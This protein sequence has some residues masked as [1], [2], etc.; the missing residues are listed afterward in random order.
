MKKQLLLGAFILGSIFATKAQTGASCA[1]AIPITT[2]GTKTAS[3]I[4][5]TFGAYCLDSRTNIKAIWY[6]YTATTNGEVTIS[7]DL[8]VNNGTLYTN[9][10]RVSVL[11]GAT[12]STLEA[13]IGTNDDV[14]ATNYLSTLT[15]PV[16]AGQ[17][18]WIQ[19][20]NYWKIPSTMGFQFTF[21]FNAV[22]CVRPGNFDFYLPDSYSTTGASLY[23]DQSI[24]SPANY[25]VDWSTDLA[26]AP[27]T[28]TIVS[29]PAGNLDYAVAPLSGLPAS[30]NFRYYVR[31]TCSAM[32]SSG[33]QGPFYGYL[34]KTGSF[35]HT[36][37]AADNYENGFIGDFNLFVASG[38]SNPANYA[39]GGAGGVVYSFNSAT[40][41]SDEWGFSRGI[42]VA[43]GTQV[44]INYKTR[45]FASGIAA[46][47]TMDL[48]VG[49]AQSVAAQTTV[50]QSK[51]LTGTASYT[52]HTATWTAPTTGVYYFGFHN[53]SPMN[54]T[55][56]AIFLD[57]IEFI[58]AP[59]GTNDFLS[60]QLS[61]FP[62]PTSNVINI[63]NSN[64]I[65][66][67]GIEIIDLNGRTVKTIKF[68]GVAEAQVNVSDLSA[69]VYM[70]NISSDKGSVTKKIVKQ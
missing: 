67:E 1:T 15:F 8:P 59:A 60:S 34:A 62:N 42:Q 24:G 41:A 33:W 27:G 12:C 32:S 2:N 43:A 29:V 68:D 7:S 46:P 19:W 4:N 70:M 22:S 44:T 3:S 55:S 66:V 54:S 61:V 40:A 28:G 52:A 58:Q 23:W 69:G 11:R 45:L 49:T 56:T 21:N 25:E 35:T 31:A 20:D 47:M 14:S 37:N 18:Y 48:T 13:C 10:T 39:D 9:D 30:S 36:F 63:T 51:S 57:T 53:N 64:N 26:A 50:I 5:G 17:T 16:E 65:L 6:T 38:T